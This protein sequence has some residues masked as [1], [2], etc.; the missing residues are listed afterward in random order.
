[1]GKLVV[2]MLQCSVWFPALPVLM[3]HVTVKQDT[4][5]RMELAPNVRELNL[6]C[7]NIYIICYFGFGVIYVDILPVKILY[8][9][10]R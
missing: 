5:L 7:R 1:M 3:A 6:L 4:N 10:S 8:H 2:L 9:P